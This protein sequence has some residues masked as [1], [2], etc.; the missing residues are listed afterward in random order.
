MDE[1]SDDLDKK[2][3]RARLEKLCLEIESLRDAATIA[4]TENV[5]R[6]RKL[7]LEIQTLNIQLSPRQRL[8]EQAK[9]LTSAGGVLAVLIAGV[10]LFLSTS[11]WLHTDSLNQRERKED[12]LDKALQAFGE[13][14][15]EAQR[16]ASVTSLESFLN[17]AEDR[18]GERV[19]VALANA[20]AVEQS[21]TVRNAIRSV[22]EGDRIN[23]HDGGGLGSESLVHALD[24]LIA[25]SR[26]LFTQSSL[27]TNSSVGSYASAVDPGSLEARAQSIA[28]AIAILLRRGVARTDFEGV[29][30]GH[31]GLQDLALDGSSFDN[32][33]L[34]RSSFNGASCRRCTFR[35]ADVTGAQFVGSDLRESV[36]DSRSVDNGTPRQ[37]GRGRFLM[38]MV[39]GTEAADAGGQGVPQFDPPD[40]SCADLRAA[41]FDFFPAFSLTADAIDVGGQVRFYNANVAGAEFERSQIYGVD[42]APASLVRSLPVATVISDFQSVCIWNLF[43]ASCSEDAGV[44]DKGSDAGGKIGGQRTKGGGGSKVDAGPSLCQGTTAH[45]YAAYLNQS[46]SGVIDSNRYACSLDTISSMLDTTNAQCAHLPESLRVALS[47][48]RHAPNGAPASCVPRAPWSSNDCPRDAEAE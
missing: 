4:D 12:R 31:V 5:A 17:D 48:S 25:G 20:L 30:L 28:D 39:L 35:G 27:W 41:T 8:F 13:K 7:D 46:D 44:A 32:A 38:W 6:L 29:Y 22:F 47:Q 14:T 40:F 11:Q 2:E 19:L 1:P 18:R 36:F 42:V 26:V 10:G 43:G 45:A 23:P 16:L 37:R 33:L 3:Q 21:A 9:V 24:S 15:A 34:V